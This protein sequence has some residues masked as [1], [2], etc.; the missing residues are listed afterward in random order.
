MQPRRK[1]ILLIEATENAFQEDH[2]LRECSVLRQCI[3][4]FVNASERIDSLNIPG[5]PARPKSIPQFKHLLEEDYPYIHVASHGDARG[6]RLRNK[7]YFEYDEFVKVDFSNKTEL[8]FLN[9]CELAKGGAALFAL[10]AMCK[11]Q[12]SDKYVI[13]P[14]PEVYFETKLIFA[15]HFYDSLLAERKGIVEA[16]HTAG[17]L[18]GFPDL[19]YKCLDASKMKEHV[20]YNGKCEERDLIC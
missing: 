7:K 17:S 11:G 20:M 13:A 19:K 8:L 16:F 4:L 14:E 18:K 9:A 10:A 2:P 6:L 3:E 12:M 15:M 5:S 1:R